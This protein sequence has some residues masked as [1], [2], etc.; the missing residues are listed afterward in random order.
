MVNDSV[1]HDYAKTACLGSNGLK[2]SQPLS[3]FINISGRN[4][5]IPWIF[6]MEERKSRQDLRL[7][8]LVW[9]GQLCLSLNQ[10]PGFLGH[11]YLR[12]ELIDIL[13]FLYG[14]SR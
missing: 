5:S 6:F 7:P 11:Q 2:S 13:V 12:R 10:I 9:C 3:L 4:Q 1:F 14:Y 8:L